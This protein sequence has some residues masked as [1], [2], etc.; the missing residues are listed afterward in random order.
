MSNNRRTTLLLLFAFV[1]TVSLP[2]LG[3]GAPAVVRVYAH[4]DNGVASQ[5]TGFFVSGAGDI[6]TCYHVIKDAKRITVYFDGRPHKNVTI[7]AL[8]PEYDLATLKIDLGV[9]TPSLTLAKELPDQEHSNELSIIGYPRGIDQYRHPAWLTTTSVKSSRTLRD[10][11]GNR[12]FNDDIEVL[13]LDTTVYSGVSGA[14]VLGAGGV[15]GVLSGSLNE[16]GTIAWAIP[17]SYMSSLKS[18]SR[19]P[20]KIEEWPELTLMAAGWRSLAKA[21]SIDSYAYRVVDQLNEDERN[22]QEALDDQWDRWADVRFR[23]ST[24]IELCDTVSWAFREAPRNADAQRYL[25]DPSNKQQILLAQQRFEE[26]GTAHAGALEN[27]ALH[28]NRFMERL[29]RLREEIPRF[30]AGCREELLMTEETV[31]D[32]V[33]QGMAFL[34]DLSADRISEMDALQL[35][36]NSNHGMADGF[37]NLSRAMARLL[38]LD[39]G[40]VFRQLLAAMKVRSAAFEKCLYH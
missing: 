18:M 38:E 37:E 36:E 29:E 7:N 22:I 34:D 35:N 10:H 6:V 12:L 21:W 25:R 26:S 15:V 24:A 1:T 2:S 16:G 39:P 4:L 40:D 31:A 5:G 14:P 33:Q 19:P 8:A 23:G 30:D 9:R 20:D 27:T 28:L 17:I 13:P 11:K 32:A 3:A